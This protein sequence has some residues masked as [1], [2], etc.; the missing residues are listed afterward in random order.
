MASRYSKS[1]GGGTARSYSK[2]QKSG[3]G[4]RGKLIVLILILLV[5]LV[6][7]A[8][9]VGRST[10][11]TGEPKMTNEVLENLDQAQDEAYSNAA[12]ELL[13]ESEAA[14]ADSD[15]AGNEGF[16]EIELNS[17]A[18][19]FGGY[20]GIARRGK[21]G[22]IYKFVAV[23]DLPG[24]DPASHSYEVWLVKPGIVDYFSIGTMFG[25]ADGRFGIVW[26][27]SLLEAEDDLWSYSE[28]IITRE[29]ND[30]NGDPSPTHALNGTF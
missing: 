26:E 1:R 24:I 30:G 18:A 23:A 22:E 3:M 28:V 29:V 11:L 10:G 4:I 12:S 16:E 15:A 9:F 21:E 5:A 6:A 19:Q 13:P 8:L 25:R 14:K 27:S 20:S 2:S 17:S 7:I